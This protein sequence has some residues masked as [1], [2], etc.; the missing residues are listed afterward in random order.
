MGI[1]YLIESIIQFAEII[2]FFVVNGVIQEALSSKWSKPIDLFICDYRTMFDGL[3]VKTI[4]NDN[5][6]QDDNFALI[7]KLYETSEVAIKTPLGLTERRRVKREVITQGDC[8]RPIL[9]SKNVIN[10]RNTS[11]GTEIKLQ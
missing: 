8:L 6:I 2:F 3:D 7:Y 4:L 1:R 9:A 11:I 5:G 10:S